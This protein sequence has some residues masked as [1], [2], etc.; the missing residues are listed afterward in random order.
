MLINEVS[1]YFVEIFNETESTTCDNGNDG[2]DGF[3]FVLR[4]AVNCAC[5]SQLT[6]T[7]INVLYTR[8]FQSEL[9]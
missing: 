7:L 8:I 4:E 1:L 6:L 2:G 5:D 9:M 3:S